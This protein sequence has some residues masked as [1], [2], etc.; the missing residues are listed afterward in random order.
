MI[1]DQRRLRL[2]SEWGQP[3]PKARR[4]DA[5]A[6]SHHSRAAAPGAARALD[7][8]TAADLNLDDLFAGLDRTES[9]L[10]QHALY[11][12]LRAAPVAEPLDAFEALVTRLGQDADLRE[13]TQIALGRL[14]DP[15]GYDLW[16][17]A[18]PDAVETS[19][20]YALF[21]VLTVATIVLAVV[22]PFRHE[23]L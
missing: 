3:R 16:W 10:G 13:R 4:M 5:I 11:H 14:Q 23:V 17:L 2:R 6:A 15:H 1:P 8:R 9:T 7:D 21:L 20:W 22:A 12:R 19:G 18:K